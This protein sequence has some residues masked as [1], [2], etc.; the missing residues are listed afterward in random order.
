[1]NDCENLR[2]LPSM[3][4]LQ[5]LQVLNFNDCSRI[6]NFPDLRGIGEAV[7]IKAEGTAITELPSPDLFPKSIKRLSVS[8]CR[9]LSPESRESH[10]LAQESSDPI[11]ASHLWFKCTEKSLE[12][13]RISYDERCRS[14]ML[15]YLSLQS[16]VWTE[17]FEVSLSH[18]LWLKQTKLVAL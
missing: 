17:D 3:I 9:Y 6:E 16:G 7:V 13:L 5:S 11:C 15:Q 10:S 12:A 8:G 2:N 4:N 14:E 1:M 18:A